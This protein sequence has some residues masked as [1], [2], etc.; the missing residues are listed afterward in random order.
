MNMR[1][2]LTGLADLA[3]SQLANKGRPLA[4]ALDDILPDPDNPRNADDDTSPTAIEAQEALDAD[5]AERGV[6]TPISVRPHQTTPGKYIINYGHRRYSSARNNKLPTIPAFVDEKFDSY[7]Q[8]NENELRIGLTTRARAL[9][10]KG[11]LDAGDSKGEIAERMRKKNQTF[12]TEHL[13]LI[14]APACVDVAYAAGV[15]SARTLYDLRQAWQEFPDAIEAWCRTVSH[16]SREAIREVLAGFR[17]D[18]ASRTV[19][20]GREGLQQAALHDD[21]KVP[22][23]AAGGPSSKLTA[24]RH[25]EKPNVVEDD[26][27]GSALRVPQIGGKSQEVP[28]REATSGSATPASSAGGTIVEYKGRSA[29]ISLEVVVPILLDESGD[30]LE[31]FLS[32]L[33]FKR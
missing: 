2:N 20:D 21:E 9:F 32:D 8:V 28:K 12:I 33:V 10:I 30:V 22:P 18:E 4:L 6:K 16:I 26:G 17:H 25:D 19:Q 3:N 24:P 31:V 14:D 1:M 5:V 27:G 13:A 7:D 29:R 11:R 15:T 23:M